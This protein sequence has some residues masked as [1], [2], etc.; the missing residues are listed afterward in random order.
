MNSRSSSQPITT[1]LLVPA[2]L[3]INACATRPVPTL[4][5]APTPQEE[6]ASRLACDSVIG[7]AASFEQHAYLESEVEVPAALIFENRGPKY[8]S[9]A[10]PAAVGTEPVIRKA[11]TVRIVYLVDSN[12][13]AD[14][15]TFHSIGRVQDEFVQSVKIYLPSARYRPARRSGRSVAQC[16]KQSFEFVPA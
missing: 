15:T 7:Q 10:E 5:P 2:L 3:A 13:R 6:L 9:A 16:V 14:T 1:I 8:P 4:S 11:T 12:G